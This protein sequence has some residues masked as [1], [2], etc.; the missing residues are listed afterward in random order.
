MRAARALS[1]IPSAPRA[2]VHEVRI[3]T[4]PCV[5]LFGHLFPSPALFPLCSLLVQETSLLP[6]PSSPFFVSPPF[7]SLPPACTATQK[8]HLHTH[9]PGTSLDS[10]PMRHAAG[11]HRRPSLPQMR[12]VQPSL[13]PRQAPGPNHDLKRMT[14]GIHT[15]GAEKQRL[16]QPAT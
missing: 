15:E 6:P 7:L 14:Q 12:P 10:R 11:L 13:G 8:A 5:R 16:F 4:H 9:N 3:W 1:V 2:Q